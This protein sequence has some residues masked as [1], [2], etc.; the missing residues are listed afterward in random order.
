MSKGS[1]R[2]PGDKTKFDAGYDRIFKPQYKCRFIW[3]KPEEFIGMVMW[4]PAYPSNPP[5]SHHGAKPIPRGK[6]KSKFRDALRESVRKEGFRN[7]I[8]G[9]AV[10]EGLLIQ[11]GCS[12]LRVAKELGIPIKVIVMDFTGRYADCPEVTET[13]YESYFLDV[14]RQFS[15]LAD[16]IEHS[17]FIA[18][19]DKGPSD[20]AGYAWLGDDP[21]GVVDD[22]LHKVARERRGEYD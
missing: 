8:I 20:P 1:K 19:R 10:D 16:R 13:N 9:Y 12:R 4:N 7:P 21:T 2:R 22:E 17:Y 15:I 3:A 14:P 6:A 5:V 11:Y 18:R